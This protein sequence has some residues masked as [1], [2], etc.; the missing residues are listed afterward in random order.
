M[1]IGKIPIDKLKEIVLNKIG[2][3][4]DD[5]LVHA[6]I[7]EDSA[8]VDLANDLLVVSSDPITGAEQNAGKLAVYVA[9]NDLAAMGAS[10]VGIQIVL[11]LPA[12]VTETFIVSLMQ[13]IDQTACSI[14]VEI[15]G[16]HTE[17][18]SHVTKPII[19]V[20]AIG[21]VSR[22][23]LVCSANACAGDDL[24]LTKGL[25]IEG[26]Y[27][28][29]GDYRELL[30]DKGVEPGIIAT[31]REYDRKLS[32][33]EEG[34]L[35]A[36][37]GAN[38]M[39]DVTEGGLYGALTELAIASGKGFEL[40]NDDL[41][42]SLETEVICAAL[43]LDPAGLISSGSMLIAIPES[44]DL[45]NRLGEAG[46]PA[47][48]IGRVIEQGRFVLTNGQKKGFKWGEKDELWSLME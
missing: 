20:T 18:L 19:V 38:A 40:F 44:R 1:E 37:L 17:I 39:H 27:I 10:P 16:G 7:G 13:E 47:A 41:P 24:V 25:G 5:V 22:E 34:L 35:A 31:A 28:L 12:Q 8:V 3:R 43:E 45:I 6:G 33:V 14:N 42:I 48:R 26:T 23:Q 30:L 46:I 11:L 32:V 21:R 36:K 4:R 2:F 9:C 15:L 29:A